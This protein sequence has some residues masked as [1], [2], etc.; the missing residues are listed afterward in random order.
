MWDSEGEIWLIG[1]TGEAAEVGGKSGKGRKGG[2]EG[3]RDDDE[4]ELA[5][6]LLPGEVRGE[7]EATNDLSRDLSSSGLSSSPASSGG[8]GGVEAARTGVKA[9]GILLS[10]PCNRRTA[11]CCWAARKAAG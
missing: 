7:V 1:T 10:W 11:F 5:D 6:W 4:G 8:V 9:D 2:E 3:D